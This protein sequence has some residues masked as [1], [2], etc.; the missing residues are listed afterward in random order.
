MASS[1]GRELSCTDELRTGRF[2]TGP[3]LVAEACYRR[4]TT[5]RGTLRG[6]E[7]DQNYGLD[8]ADFIGSTNPRAAEASLPARIRNELTKDQRVESVDVGVLATTDAGLVTFTITI[9]VH[10]AEGPF[11]LQ[12]GVDDVT[13]SLLG[14]SEDGQ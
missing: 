4:L 9:S 5:A 8:L 12:V 7:D 10:T 14:I 6:S 1:F 11:T 2:V 13:V 3:R